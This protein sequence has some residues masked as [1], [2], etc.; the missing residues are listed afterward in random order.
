MD[1]TSNNDTAVKNID[2]YN[3][4]WITLGSE[5]DITEL[6][7]VRFIVESIRDF[8]SRPNLTILDFGCGRGWMTPY[9]SP[10]GSVTGIDFSPVGID[11][12][13]E[14][15][16]AHAKF[17]LADSTS[18]TLGL[19]ANY[20]YDIVV[21]SEV[22]EHVPHPLEL[23]KQIARFLPKKGWCILT[24]PNGNV[25]PQFSKDPRFIPQLQPIENWLTPKQLKKLFRQ[26]GFR[27]ARHE[28]RPVY[29]FTPGIVGK[30]Q[31]PIIDVLFSKLDL[32]HIYHRLILPTALY[33]MVAAQK[34]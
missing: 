34:E 6:N 17:Y 16:P 14:H 24:T 10:L 8:C 7:R 27:I 21:C 19:P 18:N 30:F 3:Q 15:Y 2:Y 4:L 31:R 32:R 20:Y 5:L 25:W 28:G 23:L 33:Q 9:L 29:S 22:I 26:A 12:A 1:E 11:F 13:K